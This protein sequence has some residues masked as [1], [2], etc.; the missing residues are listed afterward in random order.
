MSRIPLTLL[1]VVMLIGPLRGVA[2][3]VPPGFAVRLVSSRPGH[4]FADSE[5]YLGSRLNIPQIG[6]LRGAGGG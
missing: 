1:A 4:L 6:L 2:A 5:N 3:E